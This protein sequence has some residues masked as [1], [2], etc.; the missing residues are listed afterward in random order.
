MR[1]ATSMEHP[2]Q[3]ELVETCPDVG[4]DTTNLHPKSRI[5]NQVFLHIH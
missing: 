4:V 3:I 5:D 1:P 2:T